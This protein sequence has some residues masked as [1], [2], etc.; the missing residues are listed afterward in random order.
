MKNLHG[1]FPSGHATRA[2]AAALTIAY[3]LVRERLVPK[4]VALP[5]ALAIAAAAGSAIWYEQLRAK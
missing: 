2:S 3:V 1:S 5:V 4:S